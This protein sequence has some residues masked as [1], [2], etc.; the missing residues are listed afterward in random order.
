MKH[1]D[2]KDV[3]YMS[4]GHTFMVEDSTRYTSVDTDPENRNGY[5]EAVKTKDL[6]RWRLLSVWQQNHAKELSAEE[7]LELKGYVEKISITDIIPTDEVRIMTITTEDGRKGYKELFRVPTFGKILVDGVE[8][9]V[10]HLDDYHFHIR[11]DGMTDRGYGGCFHI[12]QFA[13]ICYRG[14]K[15]VE[16]A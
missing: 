16:A 2:P 4:Y 6:R 14:G 9:E 13:E 12:D 8:C 15:V 3:R 10:V 1:L 5:I 7:R 11:G